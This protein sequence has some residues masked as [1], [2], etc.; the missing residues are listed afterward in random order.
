MNRTEIQKKLSTVTSALLQEKGYI[1]PVD[2][3]MRLDRLS[4]KDYEA[5]RRGRVAYLEAVIQ[6][7]LNQISFIMK[8]L[9]RNS[10]N[11]GLKASWT[12]YNSWG[13]RGG[14]RLRFSKSGAPQIEAAYATHFVKPKPKK[15]P[16]NGE[17]V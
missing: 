11:G 2:V 12:G 16:E 7:N 9:R 3:F 1:S 10:L 5:W 8:T 17:N 15:S 6:G 4:A 13:K 14:K